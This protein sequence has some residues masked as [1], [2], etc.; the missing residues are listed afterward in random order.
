[1]SLSLI[2]QIQTYNLKG[3]HGKLNIKKGEGNM[4]N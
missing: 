3:E 4:P 1:M 2:T